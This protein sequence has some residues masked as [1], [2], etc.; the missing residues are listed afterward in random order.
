MTNEIL[1]PKNEGLPTRPD[2]DAL[3]KAWPELKAGDRIPY[4]DVEG[5]LKHAYTAAR[6][7]TVTAKWR[8]KLRRTGVVV[9]CEPGH[10]FYVASTEQVCA[11]TDGVFKFIRR[12]AVRHHVKLRVSKPI[13]DAQRIVLEHNMRLTNNVMLASKKART[14]LL[15]GPGNMTP[16]QITPPAKERRQEI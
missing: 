4:A 11:A 14:E 3:L 7:R 8:H 15:P 9:E 1:F 16:V 6:F 13:N 2:V 10:T 12:K 5:L